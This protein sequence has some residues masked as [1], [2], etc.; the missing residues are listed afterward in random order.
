MALNADPGEAR[1]W[2][3]YIRFGKETSMPAI[4][5]TD[6]ATATPVSEQGRVLAKA[7]V[8]ALGAPSVLN[9][10]PWRWRI[11][12]DVAELRADRSRQVHSIDPDGRLLTLSCGIALH[13]AR[14]ALTALGAA[15]EVTYVTD[16]DLLATIRLTGPSA[17]ADESGRLFRA[18]S[19]RRSDRRPFADRYVPDEILDGLRAAAERYGAHLHLPRRGDLVDVTVAAG[20]AATLELADPAYRADLARWV[21]R[22]ASTGDGIPAGTI[23]PPAARPVPIRDFA[24]TGPEATTVHDPVAL[25]DTC[26]RYAMLFTDADEPRDWLAAGEALSAVLLTATADGLATSMMSDLVEVDSA[27]EALRSMLAGIGHPM[28]VIRIGYPRT[29]APP[30]VAPRRPA[31]TVIDQ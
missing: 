22:P 28:I 19:A 24:A 14:T 17:P 21:N 27:R 10:Q 3:A 26:A 20:R 15:A 11:G 16:R 30:A 13:Y 5:F 7:A 6:R 18:M 31:E 29:D 12:G 4:Q 8:A 9:T 1:E 25:A 2:S 23:P